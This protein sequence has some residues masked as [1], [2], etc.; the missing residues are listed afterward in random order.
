MAWQTALTELFGIECPV[1]SA[2]MGGSAGGVLA[3]AVSRGGGLGM[4]GGGGSEPD[5]L[6]RELSLVTAET[7]RPWGVGF[8]SWADD[9]DAVVRAL[10]FR[11][12]AVMLSFGDPKPLAA[13]VRDAGVPLIVQ[14]TTLAEAEQALDAGADVLVAQGTEAGGHGGGRSVL[15]FVPAVVDAA[16]ATPVLAAGGIADG[17]G[18]AAALCLGAAGALMGTRFQ[19]SREALVPAEVLKALVE[20]GSEDTERSRVLDIARGARWPARYTARTLR[21]AFLDRWRD[22]EGELAGDTAAR[23]EYR[24]AVARG[25]IPAVPVWA[26]EALDLINDIDSATDIVAQV[27]AEAAE[28]LTAARRALTAA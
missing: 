13:P 4:V 7:T 25:E 26:G 2:P 24:T 6:E 11:P 9:V 17:R 8:L 23:A 12:S 18:V 15:P 16:G 14:V 27:S 10:A 19:A 1:V 21:N 22:R 28:A 3:T 20:G 5:W